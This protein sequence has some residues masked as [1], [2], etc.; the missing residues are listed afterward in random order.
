VALLF[1]LLVGHAL[2][3]YPLQGEFLAKAKNPTAPIPG[4]PWWQAMGAH[5]LIHAGSVAFFTGS[6]GLGIAEFF[7]H[8]GTDLMKCSGK[9][10]LNTDQALHVG[11]KVLWVVVVYA[12]A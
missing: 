11:F 10:G 12:S 3:D 4:F 2:A 6:I 1:W 5:S 9:I 8:F 7:A